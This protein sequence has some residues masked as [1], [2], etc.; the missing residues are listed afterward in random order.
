MCGANLHVCFGPTAD[1]ERHRL[2]DGND[3]KATGEY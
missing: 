3:L 1:I 2:L